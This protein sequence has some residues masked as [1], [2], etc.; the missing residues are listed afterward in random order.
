M[1][2]YLYFRTQADEDN[3]DGMDDSVYVK[4]S[5]VTGILTTATNRLTIFFNSVKNEAGNGTDDENVISD[6]VILNVTVGKTKQVMQA[7][8]RAINS[9]GPLYND[10]IIVIADD[11]TTTIGDATVDAKYIDEGIVS[12][13]A[14]TVAAALS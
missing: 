1:E 2:K 7:I 13:G 11:V 6:S 4:A 9:T 8:V 5:S 3:D 14:I 12:C 10:G